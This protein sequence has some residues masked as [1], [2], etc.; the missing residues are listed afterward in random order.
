MRTMYNAACSCTGTLAVDLGAWAW[1]LRFGN[2]VFF[3]T[4][5]RPAASR[6]DISPSCSPF[7]GPLI[8]MPRLLTRLLSRFL[9]AWPDRVPCRAPRTG[10]FLGA[11]HPP[12]GSPRRG[13]R[14]CVH[15]VEPVELCDPRIGISSS[16]HKV[17]DRGG[18]RSL[19]PNAET[20]RRCAP[21]RRRKCISIDF[22][23][24]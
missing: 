8:L 15:N 3:Q 4:R 16:L 5:G 9:S 12:A 17:T 2:F 6:G 23:L 19:P 22:N 7:R 1:L 11:K 14:F 13:P 20:S 24:P 18:P 21:Q 10:D